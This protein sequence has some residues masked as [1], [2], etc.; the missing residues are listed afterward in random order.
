MDVNYAQASRYAILCQKIYQDL[1]PELFGEF[2]SKPVFLDIKD[3]DTQ[4]VIL[5]DNA[6]V[7]V[8]FR[9]SE[10]SVDWKTNLDTPQSQASF[11]KNVIEA[12]IVNEGKLEQIYP[13]QGESRS[14]AKMHCGFT[15]AYFS[16]RNDIHT[17]IA[18]RDVTKITTTGHSLGGALASLCAVDLQ[19]N[20]TDK[21]QAIEVYTYGSPRVGNEGFRA[22]FNRRV[23]NSYR[24]V[25]GV[26]IVPALPRW[27]QGQYRHVDRAYR[28]GNRLRWNFL[29][30]RFKDHAIS[31]YIEA[32]KQ[33]M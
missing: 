18:N 3:T 25:H 2:A 7:I 21:V 1:T 24:F 5:T 26:D 10:S 12:A 15:R 32:L 27:W 28:I 31:N 17:Y 30:A 19:Y 9:G 16:V 23:P 22:S 8:V 4:C 29:S 20:F 13:Y 6:H 14:N 33:R 11:D